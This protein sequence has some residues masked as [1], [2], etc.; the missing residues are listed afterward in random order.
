MGFSGINGF[1]TH[2]IVDGQ[3]RQILE[4]TGMSVQKEN[5]T[6]ALAHKMDLFTIVY[7]ANPREAAAMAKA[8]ADVVIAHV[9][10]TRKS[11]CCET[12]PRSA[13]NSAR[14]LRKT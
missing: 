1:P 2:T 6:V 14:S 11:H 5:D 4:E 3:F 10:T 13:N 7:V 12:I 9:G 8:G